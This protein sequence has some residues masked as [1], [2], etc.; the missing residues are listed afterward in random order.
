MASITRE[1]NGRR[2]IQFVGTDGK[3]RSIRLGKMSQRMAEAIKTKVEHLA[4]AAES[5]GPLDS[6]TARWVAEIGDD[7]ADKLA[8]VSLIPERERATLGDFLQEYIMSRIDVK[9]ASKVVW[10]H[11]ERNLIDFLGTGRS[12]RSVTESEAEAFRLYLVGEKLASTTVA[13]RLQFARQFFRTMLKRKLIDANPFADVRHQGGD[14]SERQFFIDRASTTQLIDAAPDWTWRAIIA[15][16]RFG[17]LRSP[18]ETL[19]LRWAD[20]DWEKARLRVISPKT[21]HHAGKA[22]RMVPMFPE[23]RP[24][25]EEAWDAAPEGQE[26]VIP[27]SYRKAAQGPEGWRS[28]NMR[29]QFERIVKR[30]GLE[31]WPRL[32]HNLRASR[33]TELAKEFPLHVVTAWLGNT[34]QIAMKHYLQVTESDFT[35]AVQNPVQ[36]SADSPE[37]VQNPVQPV[38]AT[39]RQETTEPQ[40]VVGVR[41][42][43]AGSGEPWLESLAERTGFEPAEPSYGLTGL[44]NPR[45]RPLCHLSK[46]L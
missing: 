38:S 2:T 17:G 7:L 12:V 8:A 6:E 46:A 28:C 27:T 29:T 30:A 23:L 31:P 45:I 32:F 10:H 34:P 15:L 20:V 43:S 16:V 42:D 4:A 40:G 26:H 35:K 1:A 36:L 21:E 11:V 25:L 19:S 22:S 37:T 18:S 24:Y 3:R 39:L 44:A 9:P 41:L 14:C 33:E 13:K 5:G